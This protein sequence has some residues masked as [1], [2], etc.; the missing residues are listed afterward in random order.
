M[1]AE[2]HD[3]ISKSPLRSCYKDIDINVGFYY[4]N[5]QAS[6]PKLP[7]GCIPEYLFFVYQL[8]TRVRTHLK[9]LPMTPE[10]AAIFLPLVITFQSSS[11]V[12]EKES[13]VVWSP[14]LLRFPCFLENVTALVTMSCTVKFPQYLPT[15]V[16]RPMGSRNELSRHWP[17]SCDLG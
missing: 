6:L 8:P 17:A 15:M 3:G 2:P 4:Q 5:D 1:T 12:S 16:L 9:H 7:L 14:G 11:Q 10:A 13:F